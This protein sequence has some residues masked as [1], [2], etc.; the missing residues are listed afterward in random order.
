MLERVEKIEEELNIIR[1]NFEF[2]KQYI[3]SDKEKTE[4]LN[5]VV[6][7]NLEFVK[8]V[9]LAFE[10]KKTQINTLNIKTGMLETLIRTQDIK[11]ETQNIKIEMLERLINSK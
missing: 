6:N 11:I 10:I 4:A 1:Y 2:T 8:D 3:E 5:E 7:S 9:N